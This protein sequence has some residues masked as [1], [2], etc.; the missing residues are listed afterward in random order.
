[1]NR[2]T[3]LVVILLATLT[4]CNYMNTESYNCV[5]VKDKERVVKQNGDKTESYYLIYT[6]KG[7]FTIKDELFRGNFSSSTWYGY[8]A[9]GER[10]TFDTG[11]YRKG[12]LSMYPNIHTKPVKC[13]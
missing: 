2:L 11:G 10:Y 6:D 12:F 1:M 7:E 8:M 3:F 5:L 4:S 13:E 9:V